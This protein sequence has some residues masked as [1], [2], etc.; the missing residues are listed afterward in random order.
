M[1]LENKVIVVT[2]GV[3]DIGRAVS[4]EL[5]AQG[6]KPDGSCL[7]FFVGFHGNAVVVDHD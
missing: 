1:K 4:L 7:H 5:A 2:G 3:R 6:A